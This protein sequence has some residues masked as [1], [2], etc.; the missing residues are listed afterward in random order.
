MIQSSD[1]LLLLIHA[2]GGLDIPI[3][4][5]ESVRLT[6]RRWTAGGEL[7]EVTATDFGVS[8]NLVC[9]LSDDIN[10]SR[11][12][13]RPDVKVHSLEDGTPAFSICPEDRSAL[14]NG[15]TSQTQEYFLSIAI[16]LVAFATPPPLE[17]NTSWY[18]YPPIYGGVHEFPDVF[19]VDTSQG[20]HLGF[21]KQGHGA[22]AGG[23]TSQ[24]SCDGIT[25]LLRRERFVYNSPNR[26]RPSPITTHQVHAL[27]FPRVCRFVR[28]HTPSF[29]R[30]ARQLDFYS[31]RLPLDKSTTNHSS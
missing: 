27:L 19:Q 16:R 5:L 3:K 4:L 12:A 13:A 30:K 8:Y 9:L 2:L 6:K 18:D 25:F 22:K 26:H 21:V 10:L 31:S 28:E 24:N 1:Q 29:G 20:S 14:S 17:G 15:L 7:E 11:L 23:G